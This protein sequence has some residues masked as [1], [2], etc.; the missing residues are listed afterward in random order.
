MEGRTTYQIARVNNCI[1]IPLSEGLVEDVRSGATGGDTVEE[2]GQVQLELLQAD[3]VS[4]ATCDQTCI[5]NIKYNEG[6]NGR[7]RG[8][9]KYNRSH[10]NWQALDD[11]EVS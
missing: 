4:T 6:L 7:M 11:P 10:Q 9:K 2:R 8:M 1:G 5:K 3:T